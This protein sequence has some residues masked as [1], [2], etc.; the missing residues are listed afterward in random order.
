MPLISAPDLYEFETILVYTVSSRTARATERSCLK[1]TKN[2]TKT[3][4]KIVNFCPQLKEN[5]NKKSENT[6][7]RSQ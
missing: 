4:K 1:N 3:I 5:S 7:G 2:K 6:H